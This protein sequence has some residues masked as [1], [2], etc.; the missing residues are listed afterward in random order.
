ML[1]ELH[2]SDLG[3]IEDLDLSFHPGLNVLTGETGAGKTLV[4][5]ALSLALGRRASAA[6]VREGA[7]TARVQARFDAP[8][9]AFEQGWA[10]DGT[11]I[12]ARTLDASG[13]S[14]AR[15]GGE[16]A[17]V[18]ALERLGSGLV[19]VHGQH[20]GILLRSAAAQTAFLDR[21]VGPEHLRLLSEH[22]E[23]HSRLV[24]ARREL[25]EL[26]RSEREREREADVLDF[27]IAE[28]ES[29]APSPGELAELEAEVLRLSNAERLLASAEEVRRALSVDGGA[30]DLLAVAA[31]AL[32]Q[33][34]TVDPEARGLAGRA[35]A[36]GQEAAELARDVR[37][38]R[39]RVE[40]DPERLDEANARIAVLRGLIRKYGDSEE[41]VLGF[42]ELARERRASLGAR[43][44]RR[45]ALEAV[46][47]ELEAL[48]AEQASR[49]RR[50][51]S[52]AAPRLAAAIGAE[53][54]E[55][56]MD[57]ASIEIALVDVP[58]GATGTERAEFLLS[59]GR[60]QRPLP[61]AK[62]ASG[63]ELS[64]AMLA[65]RSVLIDADDVPTLVF[66]EVDAGIGGAAAAAVGRRLARLA[67]DRQV[68]VV[69]HLPQ[70]AAF[71]D[72][73]ILVEKRAGAAVAR[74]VE[75][76]ARI[77]E[78]SRMLAGLPGSQAAS[79]HAEELLTEAGRVKGS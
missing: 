30:A 1:R 39:D 6:L 38:Y 53:L 12:L 66:D 46:I 27:Q 5:V 73:H 48:A 68:L 62:V 63:G 19:E 43:G 49:I 31:E 50:A 56:G 65:C 79:V 76:D 40:A 37:S 2:A 23:A 35:A 72:R 71:A 59:G 29:A 69:T 21:F 58:S 32:G 42:L 4:T 16:L 41:M 74:A 64:R 54:V 7:S 52:E 77:A 51:R 24:A 18:A 26:V 10:E 14:W 28:I 60:R 45:A 13:R 57:G 70:I 67:R 34:A 22:A 61:L 78:L 8:P 55:L 9:E 47:S 17:P 3:V 75:N 20:E 33:A 15:I 36:L 11:L 44:E 25:E